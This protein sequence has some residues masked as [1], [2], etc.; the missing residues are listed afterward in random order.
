[1]VA[2]YIA[3]QPILG[4]CK[5]MVR[6]PGTWVAKRWQEQ[7]VLDMAGARTAAAQRDRVEEEIDR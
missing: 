2:Q 6:M 3:T 5:E 7:E 1:M 4:L